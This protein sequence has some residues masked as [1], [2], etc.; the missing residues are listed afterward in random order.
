MA[1]AWMVMDKH[2]IWFY[3]VFKNFPSGGVHV[4]DINTARIAF[5]VRTYK[6]LRIN[7]RSILNF[8]TCVLGN[9]G[10]QSTFISLCLYCCV[11]PGSWEPL[12]LTAAICPFCNLVSLITNLATTA[13]K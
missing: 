7:L 3:A 12:G 8:R 1:T 6:A 13:T 4:C 2:A 11:Q 9:K 5:V 10:V